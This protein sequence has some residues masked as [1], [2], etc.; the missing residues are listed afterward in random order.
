MAPAWLDPPP[1]QD[2]IKCRKFSGCMQGALVSQ[3]MTSP[4]IVVEA[5]TPVQAAA[6]LMLSRKIRRLPVVD[7]QGRP[8]G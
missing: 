3:H 7:A 6:D 2:V 1:L 5:S 8:V 4:A